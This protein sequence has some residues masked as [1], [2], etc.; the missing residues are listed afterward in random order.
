MTDSEYQLYEQMYKKTRSCIPDFVKYIGYMERL[1]EYGWN[2]CKLPYIYHKKFGKK[3][4]FY[5]EAP[6]DLPEE[7]HEGW[8][9][10]VIAAVT[11]HDGITYTR[12]HK[13]PPNKTDFQAF[14]VIPEFSDCFVY[15]SP[16]LPVIIPMGDAQLTF[17]HEIG[18]G[19]ETGV[20][21]ARWLLS[22]ISKQENGEFVF[23]ESKYIPTMTWLTQEYR[24]LINDYYEDKLSAFQSFAD[25]VVL[26]CKKA[27]SMPSPILTQTSTSRDRYQE[28]LEDATRRQGEYPDYQFKP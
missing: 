19:F 3:I 28:L 2:E 16:G 14:K 26:T 6:K 18:Y 21:R 1:R 25:E 8:V 15:R 17:H 11:N 23:D 20:E 22:C 27:L 7:K 5:L 24:T 9:S 10:L 4:C 12:L 13:T